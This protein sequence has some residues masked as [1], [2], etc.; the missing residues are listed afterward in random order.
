MSFRNWLLT[1]TSI[2]LL[3]FAPLSVVQ[4]QD[5]TDPAL[6][7]AYQAFRADQS[8]ANRQALTEACIAAG[9]QSLDDC[10]AALSGVAPVDSAPPPAEEPAPPA[11]QPAPPPEEP[12]PPVEEPAPPPPEPAPPPAE[13]P[14]PPPVEEPTPPVEE[15]APPVEEPAPPAEEPAPPVEEPAPPPAAEEPAPAEPAP[16]PAAEEAAPPAEAEPPAAEAPD[17]LAQLAAAVD[18]Y[19]EGVAELDAGNPAGQAKVDQASGQIQTICS[20]AG[21]ADTQSC[22]AQFGFEL[23]PLP[24]AAQEPAP[25]EEPAVTPEE[26]AAEEPVVD[27]PAPEE[28]AA[29]EGPIADMPNADEPVTP[30]ATEPLPEDV[31]PEEAAPILDSEKDETAPPADQAPAEEQPAAPEE[32]VAPP[33]SDE[34]AQDELQAPPP[35]EQSATAEEGEPVAD[36]AFDFGFATP[37]D[38]PPPATPESDQPDQKVEVV[39]KPSRENP[40]FIF[41]IGINIYI[42]NVESQRDRYYDRNRDEIY[43][44]DLSRGRIRETIVRPDGTR[45]VTVYNRYGEVLKRTK[46]TPDDREFYLAT[47]DPR[48]ANRD[49]DSFFLDVGRELPPLRLNIPARDYILDAGT[50]DEDEVE[51]FLGQ[52]PVEKVRRIYSI[53][54]VKRSARLRDSVRRLEVGN[55][56]FDTGKA[57]I[58]RNQVSSLSNVAKAMLA[59]LDRNPAEVFLIEGHTDAVGSDVSNLVLSDQRAAT[60]ARILTDFYEIPPENLVTQGYGERYL[61]VKTEAAEPLNRRVTVKRITP[62]VTY[63]TASR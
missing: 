53:D 60:V 52:P 5:A 2:T 63:Q 13:E 7:A 43:Y 16:P 17:V 41:K 39:Q 6:V 31:Q 30:E 20:A 57:T 18:L 47:Y 44:E 25:A 42:T 37:D 22:L 15:P 3:A 62:L 38:V 51:L 11:E 8:D 14:A 12:A 26:P 36:G 9:F 50:A 32:P 4:A 24:P 56:T 10:I 19:N 49:D 46:V 28:P 54:E 55:L 35:E 29:E 34:A 27:E 45:I 59:L 1:G 33:P 23:S 61:K 21:F 48:Q 58:S 40:N